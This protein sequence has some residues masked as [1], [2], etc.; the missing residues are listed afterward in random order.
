[1][2]SKQIRLLA[3]VLLGLAL[4]L[5]LLAW[6]VGRQPAQVPA[7]SN[8]A[9]PLH[10][11]VVTTRAAEAGKPLDADALK[12]E[13]LPIDPAGAYSEVARVTGQVPLLALGANVP[14]LESQ[15]LAG[16]ATQVRE[17]E[18]AVAVSVDE[19]IGVGNQ[20]QPG[21]YVDV[22]LVLRRDQQEIP[23]SQARMLLSRLR[24]LAYGVASV[25]RPQNAKPE[26]MMARQEGAKTAVLSVPLEQVSRLAM[27]QQSGRLL[28]ALRNPQDEAMPSD[29]MFAEPQP[30]LAARAGVPADA[31]RAA[32]DKAMAGVV[33]SGLAATASAP[34]APVAAPV[35]RPLQVAAPPAPALARQSAGVEVIRAGKREI[36]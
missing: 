2:T 17:G 15:L 33:L 18:R 4:L 23:E 36:E 22:F 30:A 12:V 9:R 16:L 8:A 7:A 21:D 20:V 35:P 25:N 1:M 32:P 26:Q 6:Q 28:L 29:G 27:A 11:V 24:V 10:P 31:P 14:V 3:G 5:A 13:M 34:R 19:V